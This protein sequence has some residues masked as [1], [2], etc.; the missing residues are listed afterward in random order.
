MAPSEHL[1]SKLQALNWSRVTL[2]T[3]PIR[4]VA[5]LHLPHLTD[6]GPR[7]A[8]DAPRATQQILDSEPS[9]TPSL[10]PFPSPGFT[11]S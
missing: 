1:L 3:P 8:G 6:E 10:P 11:F 2:E 5:S 7:E 9:Q 4:A